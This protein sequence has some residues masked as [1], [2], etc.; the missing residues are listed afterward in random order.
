MTSQQSFGFCFL[1]FVQVKMKISLGEGCGCVDNVC[2]TKMIG[3][4]GKASISLGC[5]WAPEIWIHA[6]RC[7]HVVAETNDFLS[8][9]KL[10]NRG[11][12]F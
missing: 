4:L 10:Q 7:V 9:L 5:F 8:G 1:E 3:A 11:Q 2:Q 6:P 12:V